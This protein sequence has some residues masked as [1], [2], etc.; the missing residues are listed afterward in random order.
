MEPTRKL[1]FQNKSYLLAGISTQGMDIDGQSLLPLFSDPANERDSYQRDTFFWHYP[2]NVSVN[3][4]DDGFPLT[5]HSAVRKGDYK[6]IFDWHGRLKLYNIRNDISEKNNLLR[7][8][9]GRAADMFSELVA[10]LE[11]N[12]GRPYWPQ[13]NPDYDPS[14]EVR[15][16]PF[17]DLYKAYKEGK[18]V[19]ALANE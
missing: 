9:P 14:K 8:E 10:F 2:F 15:D 19:A 1:L 13:P 12:V 18:D 7:K 11:D 3:N 6:L 17:V 5:P 4:P 16:V